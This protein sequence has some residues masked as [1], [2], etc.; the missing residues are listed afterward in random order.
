MFEDSIRLGIE[1][2]VKEAVEKFSAKDDISTKF[3]EPVVGYIDPTNM[4]F[5]MFFTRGLSDHPKNIY[6]PGNTIVLYYVPYPAD[7]AESNFGGSEPSE[8]WSRAY[9]ESMW[10][11]MEVNAVIRDYLDSLGILSSLLNTPLDW[12]EE[13]HH[14]SWSHKLAA[15]AAGM[16]KLGPAGSFYAEDGSCGRVSAVISTR[17]YAAKPELITDG[18][19]EEAH[20]NI[21]T[22]CCYKGA[23]N[24]SCSDEMIV[25][26]PVKAISA[27]GIDM[28]K[29]QE[30][31]KTIDENIPSPDVCGK[32]FSFK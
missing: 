13:A 16:G 10:L 25:A 12:D 15:F 18:Q 20:Q 30:H 26:C 31:C 2:R 9:I 23:K 3:G 19:L 21:L 24:V 5:D 29:C 1:K 7:V 4:M 6:R 8:K 17:K 11:V 14:E 28:A 27:D 22:K 32:C